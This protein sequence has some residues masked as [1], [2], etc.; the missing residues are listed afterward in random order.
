LDDRRAKGFNTI[1]V[2]LLEH[3]YSRNAP[4][5]RA[6]NLPFEDTS[7][8]SGPNDAYFD[9]AQ[10][11]LDAA[12]ERGFYIVLA[13]AYIGYRAA[14]DAG[15]ARAAGWYEELLNGGVENSARYGTYLARRFGHYEN[16][17]WC[18]GGDFHPEASLP[19]LDTIARTLKADG[20]KG[21]FTGHVHP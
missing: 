4:A 8:L 17:M 6:G 19:M 5:D 2:N 12:T 15:S 20:A 11:V 16:I 3:M 13:P 18:I 10:R 9:H 1:L 14:S 7:N 21:L